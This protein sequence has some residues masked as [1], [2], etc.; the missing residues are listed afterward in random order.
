MKHTP[1]KN[2]SSPVFLYTRQ[3]IP[4]LVILVIR[5]KAYKPHPWLGVPRFCFCCLRRART[6][7]RHEGSVSLI[8]CFQGNVWKRWNET[9]SVIASVTKLGL[10][11]HRDQNHDWHRWF[12]ST[13]A[14]LKHKL[15][16]ASRTGASVK[17]HRMGFPGCPCRVTARLNQT[18]MQSNLKG[19][20]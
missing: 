2:V 14:A 10:L 17:P 16:L 7:T 18:Q 5:I 15:S 1:I 11:T 4:G 19:R 3:Q 6:E 12:Q 13:D 20:L 8:S 9:A